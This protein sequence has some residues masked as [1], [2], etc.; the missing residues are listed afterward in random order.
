MLTAL[1]TLFA[2]P[3]YAQLEKLDKV[4]AY[5]DFV[6]DLQPEGFVHV[7]EQGALNRFIIEYIPEGESLERW[8]RM[9]SI[10]ALGSAKRLP[11]PE[12]YAALFF[13]Q[14]ESACTN[15]DVSKLPAGQGEA[16]F[17]VA[18]DPIVKGRTIPGGEGLTWEIGVYRFVQTNEAL[19]QI[20]YVEHGIETPPSARREQIFAEAAAAVDNVL[21]CGLGE[22]RPCPPLDNYLLGKEPQPVTGA[23]PCRSDETVPCQPAAIYEIPAAAGL[24]TNASAKNVMIGLNFAEQDLSSIGTLERYASSIVRSLKAGHPSVMMVIRGPSPDYAMTS[25]DRVRVGTFL[26]VLRSVLV[27]QGVV[28]P[29]NMRFAFYNFL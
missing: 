3:S 28:D 17:R 25:E 27:N 20:H 1:M 10:I 22:S 14:I 21:V 6:L 12:Q 29:N 26:M 2:T 11:G 24:P 18:C 4:P 16:K 7:H 8:S 19:Y 5:Q 23:P 13:K 9:L 15:L